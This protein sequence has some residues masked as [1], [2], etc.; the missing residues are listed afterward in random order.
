MQNILRKLFSIFNT[1]ILFLYIIHPCCY[2]KDNVS[3]AGLCAW[4]EKRT[5]DNAQKHSNC[6][7]RRHKLLDDIFKHK[8]V[9]DIHASLLRTHFKDPIKTTHNATMLL[10][11]SSI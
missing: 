1:I 9:A 5:M 10:Y 3:E 8:H 7:Y 11:A 2:L 4:N 6:M